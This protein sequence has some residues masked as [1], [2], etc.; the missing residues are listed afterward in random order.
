MSSIS[1]SEPNYYLENGS[2]SPYQKFVYALR[3]P[4]TKR[5]YPRRFQVFLDF[6]KLSGLTVDEKVDLFYQLV[7]QKGRN[8]LESELIT[9]F[10]Y[11]NQRV[12]RK[13]I[14][15]ETIKNFLK[16]VKLFCEMN[17]IIINWKIISKG[18]KRGD[19]YSNDRPPLRLEIKKLI[20][21][22]D[23][24]IK[25][26]VLIMISSGIR[27]G[28]WSF[29]KWGDIKPIEKDGEF[30]G[31]KIRIFNT[32]SNK[33]YYSFITTEAYEAVKEWMEFRESFGEKISNESWV[34][35]NLWQ[36]KSQ[37]YGNYLGLAKHPVQIKYSRLYLTV[38][39]IL[40]SISQEIQKSLCIK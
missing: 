9:F 18:I 19:R 30:V 14:S 13:E 40:I 4:E 27:V 3:A 5:Q 36:I 17:G 25:P 12:E 26:I 8:W 10:T 38:M 34:M 11:Q 24:R 29:L 37:R 16:P 32:K 31:A 22:P 1:S 23:R 33:Y 2:L 6:L 39:L 7:K 28:S 20:E 15:T 21:Y 35:R